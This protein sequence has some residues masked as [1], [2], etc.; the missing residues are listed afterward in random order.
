M[1]QATGC[2]S[3]IF[4]RYEKRAL[5]HPDY[6]PF[7][8]KTAN[9]TQGNIDHDAYEEQLNERRPLITLSNNSEMF[10]RNVSVPSSIAQRANA[11]L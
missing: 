7:Y 11:R 2:Y 8:P 10:G 3:N 9:E 4:E 6:E 1:G 5:H